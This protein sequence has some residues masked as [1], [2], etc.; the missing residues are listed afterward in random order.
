MSCAIVGPSARSA[1]E[2]ESR[3]RQNASACAS[4][5]ATTASCAKPVFERGL[6]QSFERGLRAV[7]RRR[8]VIDQHEP[9][10]LTRERRARARNMLEHQIERELGDELETFDRAARAAFHR[11]QQLERDGGRFDA[12]PAGR[13]VGSRRHQPQRRGGNDAQRPLRPDQQMIEVVAAIVLL[14]RREPVVA[15]SVGQYRLDPRDQRPHRPEPQHLRA[16][17]IGRDQPADRRTPARAERQ[18]K[19]HRLAPPPPRADWRGSHP[20]RRPPAR[21]AASIERIRFIRRATGSAP[22]RRRAGSRRRP[23]RYCRPAAPARRRVRAR[24]RPRTAHRRRCRARELRRRAMK[25]PAPVGQPRRDVV[26]IG[27]HRLVARLGADGVDQ[28]G[29]GG[30]HAGSG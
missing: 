25:P 27:D 9:R 3:S 18:R 8:D 29:L 1:S 10:M 24:A 17:G 23:S 5:A 28:R 16:P 19:A 7:R 20:P 4:L 11:A 30:R 21:L 2:I 22:I 12:E 14:E 13:A 15:R 6:H 26:G